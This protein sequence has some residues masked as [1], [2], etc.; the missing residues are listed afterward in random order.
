MS[1]LKIQN[2][3]VVRWKTVKITEKKY[4]KRHKMNILKMLNE[5]D[6]S[7]D[8]KKLIT[9]FTFELSQLVIFIH[10]NFPLNICR[11]A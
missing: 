5:T 11:I 8:L 10:H 4:K 6:C 7:S 9:L 2:N 1:M 3:D